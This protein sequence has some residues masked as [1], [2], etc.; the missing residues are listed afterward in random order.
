MKKKWLVRLEGGTCPNFFLSP[1][2]FFFPKKY[3]NN[4]SFITYSQKILF[5]TRIKPVALDETHALTN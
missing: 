1:V 3:I 2:L 5:P 4:K